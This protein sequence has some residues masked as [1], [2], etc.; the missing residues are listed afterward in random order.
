MALIYLRNEIV[1]TEIEIF[2]IKK[3]P[4]DSSTGI[5]K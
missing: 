5:L 2:V 1:S 4:V 3:M